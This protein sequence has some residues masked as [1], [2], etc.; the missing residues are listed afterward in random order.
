[1]ICVDGRSLTPADVA[2]IAAGSPVVLDAEARNRMASSAAESAR[3]GGPS[4]LATK[5][6]WLVGGA[7]PTDSAQLVRGF[8]LGHCAGVGE[9][10]PREIVRAA[11]ACR[12]NVL[13]TGATGC[14]PAVADALIAF[15]AAD[16]VPVVPSQGSVGAAGSPTMAHIVRVLCGWGGEA[17]RNGVRMR[18]DA[19][20]DGLPVLAPDETEALALI[21]GDSAATALAA[22]A[23]HRAQGLLDTALAACALSFEVVRADLDCLS[24]IAMDARPHAGAI[25]VA[26][27]LREALAGSELCGFGRRP[28]PFSIRCAP[29]V[30]GAAADAID[31]VGRTVATELNA[32]IDN[33][34]VDGGRVIEAGNFHGAPIALAMDQLKIALTTVASISERRIFRLTYG[35]LSGLPSF[36]APGNGLNN[37]LMLAQYTAASLVSECKGM[38]HP[39]S[40]DTIPAVQHREDHVSMAPIA[41][42]GAVRIAE[43][44]ADVLAIE[45]MCAAQG[46]D[47]HLA[48]EAVGPD[49]RLVAVAPLAAAPGTRA[50]YDTVRRRVPRWVEDRVLHPDLAILGRAVRAGEFTTLGSASLRASGLPATPG[51]W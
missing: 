19:A 5:W 25:R 41:A 42:R 50:V 7:V 9:P 30:L 29:A 2:A 28:D 33:P 17:W 39:A 10:L 47:F 18:A 11:I 1:M 51:P 35:Q 8:V 13:A 36:L 15:L 12:L 24:P 14:R 45:L 23:T 49:G 38:S 26:S 6:A 27:R 44:V 37:G 48:G 43:M 34:I 46:L 32:T 16:V 40:V 31:A 22:L 20:V 4:V 21:N 3:R